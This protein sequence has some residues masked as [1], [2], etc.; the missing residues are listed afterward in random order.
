MTKYRVEIS[1]FDARGRKFG[2]DG[3]ATRPTLKKAVTLVEGSAADDSKLYPKA[4]FRYRILRVVTSVVPRKE[5]R[6][7]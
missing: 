2:W 4:H 7:R 1:G 5:W 3:F 6:G